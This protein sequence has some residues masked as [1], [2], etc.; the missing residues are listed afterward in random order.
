MMCKHVFPVFLLMLA[1]AC[2]QQTTDQRSQTPQEDK[3]VLQP[4]DGGQ[5]VSLT[6]PIE[7]LNFLESYDTDQ[8]DIVYLIADSLVTFGRDL[9]IVP[10]LATSW[11]IS[12][13]H[14]GLT[15]FL[16]P[17]ARFHD[18]TPLTAADVVFSYEQSLNP[19]ILWGTYRSNFELVDSITAPDEHTVLVQYKESV[20]SP[21]TSFADF[22]ILPKHIYDRTDLPIQENPANWKPVGSGPYRLVKWEKNIR[23]VLEANDD[24]FNGRPHLDRIVFK[25][26]NQNAMLF[27]MLMNGELD[28]AP[29]STMEWQFRTGSD[30]FLERFQKRK[31]FL[32][33]FFFTGWNH[34]NRF[35]QHRKVRQAMAYL[36]DRK[37]FNDATYFSQYRIASS[38]VHPESP[39][40][41]HNVR[42]FPFDPATALRLL[43]EAGIED[44][45]N[46]GKLEDTDGV[47]FEFDYMVAA[48][49]DR[50]ARFAEFYQSTLSDHGI[51][52]NIVQI[53]M[54]RFQEQTNAGEYDAYFRGWVTGVD[55][56]FLISIFR[57]PGE[58][59]SYNDTGYS[60]PEL[61]R[62]L[63]LSDKELNPD[64][65]MDL[66]LR[67]QEIIHDD[68]PY[69]FLFYPAA[70]VAVHSRYRALQ[71]SAR[72]IFR[73]YPGIQE[74]FI[75]LPLQAGKPDT[76]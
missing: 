19:E 60:N 20:A 14:K 7:T 3:A 48:G 29:I 28:L 11:E 46:D 72:G 25:I 1:W 6:G 36:C 69:L 17:N 58:T 53:D 55:P 43:K 26:V 5:L 12:E 30:E 73:W 50:A 42:P 44:R 35:F 45:N 57:T 10:R 21:L 18:G 49:D 33:A 9:T 40:F 51:R 37:S 22:F 4:V 31:Y 66:F 2:G 52:M 32:L 34:E 38:P 64:A 65:R 16:H 71:P 59:E 39:F 67:A 61:D 68:Q 56:D 54:A 75:P 41:N 63:D 24:Y 8:L 47:P 15:F 70:L 23:I 13:D 74:A 62:I 27:D 76:P